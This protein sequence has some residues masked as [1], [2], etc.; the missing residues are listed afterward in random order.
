MAVEQDIVDKSGAWYAY[1]GDRIGQGRE[2]AKNYMREHQEMMLEV[3]AR[4]RDAYGIGTGESVAE[5]EEAQE[6][7]PLDE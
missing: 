3:S 4:V 1:K 6:E 7:L 2:N 5:V